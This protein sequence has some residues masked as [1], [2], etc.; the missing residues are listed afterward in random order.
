MEEINYKLIQIALRHY[1]CN[2]E[3][4][5]EEQEVLRYYYKLVD[6]VSKDCHIDW[7]EI[8]DEYIIWQPFESTLPCDVV[9]NMQNLYEDMKITLGL[10]SPNVVINPYEVAEQLSKDSVEAHLVSPYA[11][12]KNQDTK[13][14]TQ[15][16]LDLYKDYHEYYIS[17]LTG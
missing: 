17:T 5:T 10:S 14:Y 11:I 15:E 7:N 1:F 6:L 3:H 2:V 16:A 13:E 12:F 4:L 9:D 8:G